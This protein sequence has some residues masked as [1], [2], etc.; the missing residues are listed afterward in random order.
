[1]RAY[2]S[3]LLVAA[4]TAS[5]ALAKSRTVHK[6]PRVRHHTPAKQIKS[7]NSSSRGSRGGGSNDNG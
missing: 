7:H 6:A 2:L 5:P 4:L 3:L 1:M